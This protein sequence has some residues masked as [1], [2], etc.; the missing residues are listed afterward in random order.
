MEPRIT[1]ENIE[2]LRYRQGIEDVELQ[3]AIRKLRAGDMVVLSFLA[4]PTSFETLSVRITSISRSQFRGKLAS[5]PTSPGLSSLHIGFP[6][7]F[8][9]AQIHSLPRK[10][11]TS[12]RRIPQAQSPDPPQL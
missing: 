7:V 5:G 3:Q 8:T 10:Q 12:E 1:I 2:Y 6:V 4:G 9:A 11:S